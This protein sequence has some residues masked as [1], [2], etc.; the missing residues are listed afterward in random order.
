MTLNARRA[1][2]EDYVLL[3]PLCVWRSGVIWRRHAVQLSL[4]DSP[5]K[6]DTVFY[7]LSVENSHSSWLQFIVQQ[8]PD[9]DVGGL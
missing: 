9:E 1:G 8:S 4:R 7:K 5:E 3:G 6:C 2:T